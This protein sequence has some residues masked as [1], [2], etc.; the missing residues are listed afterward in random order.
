MDSINTSIH[1]IQSGLRQMNT[2]A[3]SIANVDTHDAI[4]T[5]NPVNIPDE[6]VALMQ[7]EHQILASSA[8][9]VSIDDALTSLM[10]SL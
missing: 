6:M 3:H 2:A 5:K 10:E 4:N 7:A 1:G 8:V 9:I